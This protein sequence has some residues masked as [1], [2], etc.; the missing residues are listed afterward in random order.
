MRRTS[1][2]VTQRGGP[3]P[4]CSQD[5]AGSLPAGSIS[6]A[7]APLGEQPEHPLARRGLQPH[8]NQ[9]SAA[10]QPLTQLSITQRRHPHLG[11]KT[12]P[13]QLREH[14]QLTRSVLH[15]NGAIALT[16]PRRR[17]Q[18]PSHTP[19]TV[20]EPRPRRL[21]IPTQPQTSGPSTCTNRASPSSS[22]GTV[23]ST[24]SPAHPLRT[25]PPRG[26][27]NHPEML[28][29]GLLRGVA[30]AEA[31]ILRRRPDVTS[32][33]D[34]R[35]SDANNVGLPLSLSAQLNWLVP[36]NTNKLTVLAQGTV[37]ITMETPFFSG[38]PDVGGVSFG[39]SA[40]STLERAGARSQ[41]LFRASRS[42][43]SV[44]GPR[45]RQQRNR[46]PRR[47][48]QHQPVR[49]SRACRHWRCVGAEGRPDGAVHAVDAGTRQIGEDHAHDHAERQKGSVV[50]GFNGVDTFNLV[51]LS[52]DEARG[53]TGSSSG[54]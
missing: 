37:P 17:S 13:D 12:S 26:C 44:P 9:L 38:D 51:S 21:I 14:P 10:P 15:A 3:Q 20:H 39:N 43:R 7:Q 53:E 1:G 4:L 16:F 28:H 29:E 33:A 30:A 11:H 46:E 2:D 31:Q 34:H 35:R 23:P 54:G 36:T 42:H 5:V 8:Q 27:P 45:R 49:L 32:R 19:A 6:E 41:L 22:A 25:T 52:G 47:G 50:R 40:A 24:N 18:T 48:R